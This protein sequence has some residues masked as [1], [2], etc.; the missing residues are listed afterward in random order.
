VA[1]VIARARS[2]GK[3]VVICGEKLHEAREVLE[4]SIR[5]GVDGVS[6]PPQHIV[7]LARAVAGIEQRILLEGA[8]RLRSGGKA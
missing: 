8:A 6:A 5:E 1:E 3:P 4:T 7:Q 2:A